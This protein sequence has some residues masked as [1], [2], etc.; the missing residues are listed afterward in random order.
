MQKKKSKIQDS[1]ITFN[2][3]E[4]N[5]ERYITVLLVY[6]KLFLKRQILKKPLTGTYGGKEKG[7]EGRDGTQGWRDTCP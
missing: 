3:C 2:L 6:A 5:G 7:G 1:I 4:K